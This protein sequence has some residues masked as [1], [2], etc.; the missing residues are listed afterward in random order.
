ML[1]PT[2]DRDPSAMVMLEQ[3]VKPNMIFTSLS[4]TLSLL[5]LG[6]HSGPQAEGTPKTVWPSQKSENS[7]T[8]LLLAL[9]PL[10]T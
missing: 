1:A 2:Q 6:F 3:M 4:M 9:P 8:S 5:G 7:R 10:T